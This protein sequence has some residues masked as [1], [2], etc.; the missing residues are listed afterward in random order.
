[1]IR[2]E[3]KCYN[4]ILLKKTAKN[5]KYQADKEI[6][7]S[8]QGQIREQA[9]FTYSPTITVYKKQI[10]TIQDPLEEPARTIGVA[11]KGT[12]V[13]QNININQQLTS[14]YNLFSK[15]FLTAEARDELDK[16]KITDQ[17]INGDDLIYKKG[18]NKKRRTYDFQKLKTI[19]FGREIY[20]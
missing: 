16:I 4:T 20:L 7:P 2:L 18:N 11:K 13:L 19:S 9:K 1:M 12:K 8:N 17:E 15:D 14:I 6:L 10:K 5:S 3:M